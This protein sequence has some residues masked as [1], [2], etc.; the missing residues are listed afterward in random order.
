M[1]WFHDNSLLA[2]FTSPLDND[3][4]ISVEFEEFKRE[5]SLLPAFEQKFTSED[6]CF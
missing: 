5:V 3:L 6:D 2:C 4:E 1:H